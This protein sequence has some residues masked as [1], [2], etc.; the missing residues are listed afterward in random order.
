LKLFLVLQPLR[1]Y[2]TSYNIRREIFRK[3]AVVAKDTPAFIGN[4]VG[5]IQSLFHLVKE[6]GLT[7]E[8]DKLTG[9]VI[10]RPKSATL[11][12]LMSL[13]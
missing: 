12:Q 5:G 6:M 10:G 3:T 7:I 2:W 4:R 13:V 8:V 9:P 11:E 1:K